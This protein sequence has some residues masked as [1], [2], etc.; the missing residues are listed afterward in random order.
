[1]TGTTD[2]WWPGAVRLRTATQQ[3][4][5]RERTSL[6]ADHPTLVRR[7]RWLY[8]RPAVL[9]LPMAAVIPGFLGAVI[10]DG[11]AG[12]FRQAGQSMLGPEPFDV[13]SSSG[14]QVGPLYL[15]FIGLLTTAV[16]AVGLPMLFTVAALQSL[17]IAWFALVTVRRWG[18][19][20]GADVP[21]AQWGVVAPMVFGGLLA[22]SIGNGHPEEVFLGLLLANAA[23]MAQQGRLARPG[24]LI[25]LATGIK[26]WGL[27][28]APILL[29]GRRPRALVVGGLSILA[30]VVACY[31]PFFLLGEVNTFDFAWSSMGAPLAFL[32]A[33]A[34]LTDWQLRIVQGAVT[35]A[36]GALVAIRRSGSGLAVVLTI[37]CVRLVLDPL[38]QTYYSGPFIVVGLMWLWTLKRG[39]SVPWRVVASLAVPVTIVL[40][41]LILRT[42]RV[43][44]AHAAFILITVGVLVWE[45]NCRARQPHAVIS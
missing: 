34:G 32:A 23:L 29:I 33:I 24:A 22:E 3:W 11:D 13:F 7:S 27:L 5:S 1:M 19:E 26:L 42:P 45:R 14:L 40:P 25:G 4:W 16:E 31:V 15:L 44:L 38:L 30:I 36:V 2:R 21:R 20:L 43:M 37:I 41:Y 17:G 28:G 12:W 6:T 8:L 18:V 9:L 35:V 10:P 39:P